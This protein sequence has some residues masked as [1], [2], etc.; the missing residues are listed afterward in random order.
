MNHTLHQEEYNNLWCLPVLPILMGVY[1]DLS[2]HNLHFT[3]SWR[4]IERPHGLL[5]TRMFLRV[6]NMVSTEILGIF[7]VEEVFI[8]VIDA[9]EI[10]NA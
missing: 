10:E 9:V 6:Y 7:V 4:I 1:T 3:V 8:V 5:M 2:M